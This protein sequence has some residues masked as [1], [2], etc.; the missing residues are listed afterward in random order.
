[1]ISEVTGVDYS[2]L[3]GED[4]F[5]PE[6][7]EHLLGSIENLISEIL[8]VSAYLRPNI[9][10]KFDV[11]FLH[12]DE[13][14]REMDVWT[15]VDDAIASSVLAV[16]Q[17]DTDQYLFEGM[18][19]RLSVFRSDNETEYIEFE[20]YKDKIRRFNKVSLLPEPKD[21]ELGFSDVLLKMLDRQKEQ[22]NKEEEAR[23][24]NIQAGLDFASRFTSEQIYKLILFLRNDIIENAKAV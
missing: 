14:M 13:L 9:E 21:R 15:Y 16:K 12:V 10:H 2:F 8:D 11:A 3:D 19:A 1:M 5:A 24:M 7:D 22:K 4:F 17:H 20:I 23:P 6:A 18:L